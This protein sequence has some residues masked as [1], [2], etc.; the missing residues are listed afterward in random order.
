MPDNKMIPKPDEVKC[1]YEIT[2]AMHGTLD[3]RKALYKVL[4]LL[5]EYLG[6]NRG[7][8]SLL[9]QE[10][11]EIHIEVAHGISS[12]A[13]TKG[14]YKLGEAPRSIPICRIYPSGKN[15]EGKSARLL[16]RNARGIYSFQQTTHRLSSG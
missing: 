13:K 15:A 10:K 12:S 6:M 3:L 11:S 2:R 8:I 1:L 4:D 16:C 14:R 5:E 7:S 9:N